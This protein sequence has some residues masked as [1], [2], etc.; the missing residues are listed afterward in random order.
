M[1]IWQVRKRLTMSDESITKLTFEALIGGFWSLVR[2][3]EYI[4]VWF[5][6]YPIL[7]FGSFFLL[8]FFLRSD[9]ENASLDFWFNLM[10]TLGAVFFFGHKL[11]IRFIATQRRSEE[12]EKSRPTVRFEVML[13]VLVNFISF[14]TMNIQIFRMIERD[15]MVMF[16]FKIFVVIYL[17]VLFVIK[18]YYD[19]YF[20]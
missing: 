13:F 5:V 19:K 16:G 6:S 20:R 18:K 12:Y 2:F 15:P 1:D 10:L 7:M 14:Y 4:L 9:L 17:T 8:Q 11:L 3:I